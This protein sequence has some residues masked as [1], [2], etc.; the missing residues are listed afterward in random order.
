M[1]SGRHVGH[2][3]MA[4]SIITIGWALRQWFVVGLMGIVGDPP[5]GECHSYISEGFPTTGGIA[6]GGITCH[7]HDGWED[8]YITLSLWI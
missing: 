6:F 7:P 2:Q 4:S 8:Q 5:K 3:R 1:G